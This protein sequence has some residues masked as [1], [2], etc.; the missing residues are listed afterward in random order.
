MARHRRPVAHSY[1]DCYGKHRRK[2][3][4]HLAKI[5]NCNEDGTYRVKWTKGGT[6][7]DNIKANKIVGRES[8][9]KKLRLENQKRAALLKMWRGVALNDRR[10]CSSGQSKYIF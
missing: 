5:V 2:K 3:V 8:D 6:V 4:K 1:V 9:L 10:C 7:S